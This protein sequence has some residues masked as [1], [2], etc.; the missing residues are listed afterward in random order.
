MWLIKYS[1]SIYYQDFVFLSP[2]KT[3]LCLIPNDKFFL[4]YFSGS[5]LSMS[6]ACQAGWQAGWTQK[7]LTTWKTIFFGRVPSTLSNVRPTFVCYNL[8]SMQV[9]CMLK[10][11]CVEKVKFNGKCRSHIL[12]L[13]FYDIFWWIFKYIFCLIFKRKFVCVWDTFLVAFACTRGQSGGMHNTVFSNKNYKN[14]KILII[15]PKNLS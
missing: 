8:Q 13:D 4:R 9:L 12:Y 10:S 5:L 2:R 11:Q 6:P 14:Q 3:D 1:K 7:D 15:K